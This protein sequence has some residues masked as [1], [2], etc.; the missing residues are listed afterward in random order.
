MSED[1]LTAPPDMPVTEAVALLLRQGRKRLVVVDSDG[2]AVGL[3]DRQTLLA[4][5]INWKD[6]GG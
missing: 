4:A 6:E 1:V 3:V 5:S 2:R